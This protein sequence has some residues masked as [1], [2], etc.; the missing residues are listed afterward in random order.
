MNR[1]NQ[2]GFTLVELM[3]VIAILAI[4]VALAL[5]TYQDYSIRAK[6]SEGLS[7]AATAKFA[8]AEA[9]SSDVSPTPANTGFSGAEAEYVDSVVIANDGSGRITIT[10]R[11][12]GASPDPVYALVPTIHSAGTID[13]DCELTT[14][15]SKYVPAECRTP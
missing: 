4:L 2:N 1:R 6:V 8:V 13:W 9:V 15:D 12:T 14:G 3:I 5:P 11:N 10:T 7:V